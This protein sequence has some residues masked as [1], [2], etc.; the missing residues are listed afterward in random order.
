[1][2][3]EIFKLTVDCFD[4][5]FDYVSL[6]DVCSFGQTCKRMQKVAGDYFKRNYSKIKKYTDENGIY[7]FHYDGPQPC[8]IKTPVFNL[9]ITSLTHKDDKPQSLCYIDRYSDDFSSLIDFELWHIALTDWKAKYL[10]K[11]LPQLEVLK[12]VGCSINGDLYETILQR[13]KCLKE[14]RIENLSTTSNEFANCWLLHEY[15]S[16]ETIRFLR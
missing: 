3:P 12:I 6:Q 2:N 4:E 8:S 7:I 14:L 16:L 9:F 10:Q 13:C 15:P 1:M 11:I 5:I